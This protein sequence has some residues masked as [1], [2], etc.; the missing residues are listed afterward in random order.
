[1]KNFCSE[2]VKSIEIKTVS[3]KASPLNYFVISRRDKKRRIELWL[4][5][6]D[7]ISQHMQL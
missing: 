1:M 6:L 7:L 3:L 4:D 5:A 2:D